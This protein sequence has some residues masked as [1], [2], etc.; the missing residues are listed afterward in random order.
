MRQ[1]IIT[2]SA[3]ALAIAAMTTPADAQDSPTARGR[4]SR[5]WARTIG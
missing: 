3:M 5:R 4:A 1:G 2:A